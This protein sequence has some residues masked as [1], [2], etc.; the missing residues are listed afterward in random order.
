VAIA[1]ALLLLVGLGLRLALMDAQRPGFLGFIDSLLYL[2]SAR[3]ELLADPGRP[4]GYPVFLRLLHGVDGQLSFALAVQ[5]LL[6]LAT[7]LLLFLTVRRVAPAGWGLIPAAVVRLG[8]PQRLLEHAPLSDSLFTFLVVASC[9]CAARAL[10]ERP[11]LWGS[12]AA[13]LAAAAACVRSVGL[14]LPLLIVAWLAAATGGRLRERLRV[15]GLALACAWL[16]LASYVVWAQQGGGYVGPGLTRQGGINLYAGVMAFADCK[17]FTPPAG[18][19]GLCDRR[20]PDRRPG[21]VYYQTVLRSPAFRTFGS[22]RPFSPDENRKLVAFARTAI[23]HQPLDYLRDVGSDLGRFWSSDTHARPL[24]GA[25]YDR[26]SADLRAAG[27]IPQLIGDW[28]PTLQPSVDTGTLDTLRDW[29]R[30]TRLEGPVL[31]LL[32]LLALAGLPLARGPRLALSAL[33]A[34]VSVL[35]L[36][37]PV[38]SMFFDARFA[39]PGY[40]PLA[41]A[42]ALGAA[43]LTERARAWQASRRRS[44]ELVSRAQTE[45][46]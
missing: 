26:W 5:H 41:A 22:A 21:P 13:L 17:R 45:P 12:L 33:L 10:A 20:P 8:G 40:G 31:A 34:A 35:L 30:R 37:G 46:S 6:G 29:E 16:L 7:G 11:A 15:G 19:A 44:R 18:T 23:V 32:A 27:P 9:W 4:A 14:L 43:S 25:S 24:G 36:V 1:L 3:G 2:R 38:A 28:Y 39:V 42:G